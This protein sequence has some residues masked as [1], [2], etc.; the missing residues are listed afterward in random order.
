MSFS[1]FARFRNFTLENLKDILS[2]Y[3]DMAPKMSWADA[4]SLIE[5]NHKGYKRTAYQ[6]ACQFGIEDRSNDS[7]NINSY[8]FTFDDENLLNYIQFWLK[9]Y[10]APNPY[11]RNED[12]DKPIIIYVELV[13]EILNTPDYRVDF[14]NFFER[15]IGGKSK[16]ILLNALENYCIKLHYKAPFFEIA[17]EDVDKIEEEIE[18]I[19]NEFP[20]EDAES[21]KQFFERYSFENYCKFFNINTDLSSLRDNDSKR[22]YEIKELPNEVR[23][24]AKEIINTVYGIDKLSSLTSLIEVNEKYIKINTDE[25]GGNYL[26]YIFVRDTTKSYDPAHE[27]TVR[28]FPDKEYDFENHGD[29][30]KCRLTTQWKEALK[31]QGD[32]G[33]ILDILVEVVNKY[34]KDLVEIVKKDNK[35]YLHIFKYPKFKIPSIFNINQLYKRFITSILA[36]PFVILTGNSGTGKT[37]IAVQIAEYMS[38]MDEKKKRNWELVPVGADWTDNTKILG[39]YN[40]FGND[41]EGVYQKTKILELIERAND[42]P[43]VPYFLILDEMNLSHVERYFSDFLSHMETKGNPFILDGYDSENS[44]NKPIYFP[45]NLFI[46]GTVNIDETTYMFSPKVLDRANVIEFKPDSKSVLNLFIAESVSNDV[47]PANDG[48]AE[49]FLKLKKE[50]YT[51]NKNFE[52]NINIVRDIFQQVYSVTEKCGFE[53]AYRTV[54][55]ISRYI[56]ASFEISDMDA[57]AFNR[58]VLI[59]SIDEQLLQKVLPKIHGN[60][61]EIGNM[62]SELKSL[63]SNIEETLT[64]NDIHLDEEEKNILRSHNQLPLSLSKITAMEGKLANVQ[65]ASFI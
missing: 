55:E 23:Y 47:Q 30:I 14:D 12:G 44:E 28:V 39:F 22:H 16:D 46:I 15:R 9:T 59:S 58:D 27:T 6:Q 42:H 51:G 40:P 5:T 62:L 18:F 31:D 41:G 63:C 21:K 37:R 45:E 48:T 50:I 65:F 43:E 1:P 36:K 53:F 52:I 20:I 26:R 13:K 11:V 34:Y 64:K 33:N 29:Q 19:E 54:K 4:S 8:L 2:V 24:C 3:P 25:F 10:Y 32:N 35:R 7:F 56:S 38:V 49:A 60:R 57:D 61:K 17:R